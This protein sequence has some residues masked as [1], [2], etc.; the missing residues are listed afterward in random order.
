[1]PLASHAVSTHAP[2]MIRK[3]RQK[4]SVW[5]TYYDNPV[6]T[7]PSSHVWKEVLSDE[8]LIPFLVS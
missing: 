4:V 8:T 3:G 5:M 1:Y 6:Y 7:Y 2:Y